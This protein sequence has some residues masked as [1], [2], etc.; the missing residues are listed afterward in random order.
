MSQ[1]APR[2]AARRVRAFLIALVAA[3]M[4]VAGG[5]SLPAAAQSPTSAAPGTYIQI[6][7]RHTFDTRSPQATA[8]VRPQ[9]VVKPR[10]A[11]PAVTARGPVRPVTV[12][13]RG[14]AGGGAAPST[15]NG[16]AGQGREDP[17]GP[18]RQLTEFTAATNDGPT[19]PD[20]TAGVGP[21]DVMEMVNS[22]W[23]RY[24]KQG[25]QLASGS[26]STFFGA[27][28]IAMGS[29]FYSD[30]RVV[31]DALSG[32]YFASVLI[33][34]N[35]STKPPVSCTTNSD[36]EVDVA[37]SAANT[38]TNF[39]V[40]TVETTTNNV[41]LDQPKLGFSN[42]KV[43][44]TYNENG[45]SGPYRQVVI[46]KSDLLAGAA[47]AA[48]FFFALD[49]DHFNVIP[50]ISLSSTDTEFAMSANRGG[51]TLT[52][53]QFTGTPAANNV[54][55][56]TTDL[57]IGTINDP[58]GA[59]QPNDTRLLD[60]GVAGVQSVAWQNDVLEGAG[61]DSC[62]PQNDTTARS[63]LRF[64]RV[65]T[66]GGVNLAQDIDLGQTGAHLFYP[67]VTFDSG[68][69]LWVGSSVSST[70]QFATAGETFVAGGVFPT[71]VPG[72]DY[73]TGVGPYDCTFCTAA[74]G[75][76]RNRWGDFSA[77][78]QDPADPD[79]VWLAEE[80]GTFDTNST[81]NWG[82]AIARFTVAPATTTTITSSSNPS[83]FGQPVT[84]SVSVTSA[85][86]GTPTGTV[87]MTSDGAPLG[88]I[89]LVNGQG[90]LTTS[91]LAVGTHTIT[92][93]YSGDS[94]FDD[95]TGT[96]LQTVGQAATITSIV[97]SVDP[98]N[99]GQAVSFTATVTA[100]PPGAG[101]PTGTVTFRADGSQFGAPA[102]LAGGQ[103]T[104]TSI[105][106]LGPGSHTI[107]GVYS[108]DG[109][110][111]PSSGSVLQVVNCQVNISSQ[112]NGPLTVTQSTCVSGT[113]V[114]G[115][116]TVQPGGA[117]SFSGST[118]NGSL[119]ANGASAVRIC[120]DT[121][122]STLTISNSTGFVL[123]G[124]AG[125]DGAAGC[126]GS[127][128]TGGIT[129]TN[130]H[131]GAEIGGNTM[132]GNFTLTGTT[133][134]GATGEDAAPEIEANKIQGTLTCSGNSPAPTND[135]KPNTISGARSGQCSS[136]GF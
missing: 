16:A 130:N 81:N 42:D 48:T 102:V 38:A 77:A 72:I 82:T 18:V 122:H 87:T 15:A 128:V 108:G 79:D 37:V 110:F 51:S 69:N 7:A 104:S 99:F 123:V 109:N 105:S 90:S 121:L 10:S 61:N 8:P 64:D 76:S 68:G 56:S 29:P 55:K 78:A 22:T 41:L 30:A 57:G 35:C 3:G 95:S 19:P 89:G 58:P 71:V 97:S 24:D 92:A 5:P 11:P 6:H 21:S 4:A 31:Y 126:A 40:Y 101:L 53:F 60:T 118:L 9:Q 50:A 119:T 117:L 43:V 98:S 107:T 28:V 96:L 132:S 27:P 129:L 39:T 23:H 114:N 49:P 134:S 34:D 88:T 80:F 111:L 120:G 25:N 83:V 26:T 36:S 116:V 63:C 59:D 33:F 135:G 52:V 103:T 13:T 133:G 44:M 46:Q 54:A 20:T 66:S 73:A 113:T 124:D 65:S 45:F 62:T 91:A 100:S 70:T 14:T 1:S 93:A 136:P 112:F 115:N 2:A 127:L 47:S 74:N 75:D 86:A 131:G 32:R 12:L 106:S 17:P 84:F 94:T 67:G 125:D 85:A